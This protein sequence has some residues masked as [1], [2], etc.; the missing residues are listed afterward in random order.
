MQICW[1]TVDEITDIDEIN[2][3]KRKGMGFWKT[4]SSKEW[5]KKE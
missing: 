2:C 5:R 3:K 4:L 1:D